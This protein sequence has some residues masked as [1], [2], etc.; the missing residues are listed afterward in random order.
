MLKLGNT[1]FKYYI[2]YIVIAIVTVVFGGI[3]L[4]GS[5]PFSTVNLLEKIAISIILA[6]SLSMVVGFLGELS[7]GHAG[8]MCIGAYCAGA[9]YLS[10]SAQPPLPLIRKK[11]TSNTFLSTPA[12]RFY[13]L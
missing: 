13:I 9:G 7:L 12:T 11:S 1:N 6:T 8:F 5:L 4:G 2:N 3:S 10:G